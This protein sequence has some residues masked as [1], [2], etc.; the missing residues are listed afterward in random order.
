M[1][2]QDNL[3]DALRADAAKLD[4]L[5]YQLAD[6]LDVK[7]SIILVLVILLGTISGQVLALKNLSPALKYLQML[8]VL[9]LGISV[10]L[11]I[12]ALRISRFYAAPAPEEWTRSL[13]EWRGHYAPY[14]Q[15][16]ELIWEH[17]SEVRDSLTLERIKLNRRLT[18]KKSSLNK[19]ALRATT[20]GLAF[21]FLTL[22][23]LALPRYPA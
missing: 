13:L 2:A 1:S 22:A 15:A 8:S 18:Q 11:T 16:D 12:L 19:W 23:L 4:E 17:F 14:E 3:L 10:V 9:S 21:E 6:V 5:Y 20:F 7:A